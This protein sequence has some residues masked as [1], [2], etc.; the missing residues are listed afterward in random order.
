MWL[1]GFC[2]SNGG[3]IGLLLYTLSGSTVW[4]GLYVRRGALGLAGIIIAL[5]RGGI[6]GSTG[7]G[8]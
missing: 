7:F 1:N 2:D 5:G 8:V 3:W 6:T 4:G